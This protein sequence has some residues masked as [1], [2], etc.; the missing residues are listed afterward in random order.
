MRQRAILVAAVLGL[1]M[2]N[3]LALPTA[4]ASAGTPVTP[5]YWP[6]FRF[7][8][9]HPGSISEPLITPA[10][11]STLA[12]AWVSKPG[13]STSS[14]AVV[15][16]VVYSANQADLYAF[17]AADG[18]QLWS[19][20]SAANIES[21]PAVAGG[22]VYVGSLDHDLYAFDAASGQLLWKAATADYI[23]SSAVVA[24]GVV[25]IGSNDHKLYAFD[26]AGT[27]NCSG[28]PKVCLPLW[29]AT[30]AGPVVSTP[31]VAGGTVYVGSD[32][33]KLYAFD[34]AG[35]TGCTGSP[36]TCAPLWTAMTG[37]LVESSP[38]VAGGAVYVGSFDNRLYA[39]DAAG[40]TGCTGSPVTCSPLWTGA[41]GAAI[42]SSPAIDGGRVFVSSWDKHLYAFDAAGATNCSGTPKACLPLWTA[43][44]LDDI[45]ISSP[46]AVAGLVFLGDGTGG[47]RLLAFDGAGVINC[48]G[49]PTVCSPVWSAATPAGVRSSPAVAGAMVYAGSDDGSLNAFAVPVPAAP[50]AGRYHPLPPSRVLDSRDGTGGVS[51]PV[52][53][54]ATVSVTVTGRGGVPAT[55]VSAVVLNVTATGPSAVS[56]LTIFASGSPRPLTSSL[57][58]GPGQT[59][60]N[61]AVS[62]VG[63][64][65]AINVFNAYGHTALVADVVGWYGADGT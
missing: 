65:G 49:A 10:N 43:A 45:A 28:S 61:Q 23:E 12:P 8:P 64:D 32:D 3:L 30:T 59:V 39:F 6:Q 47:N 33:H 21:S 20:A 42:F 26:A 22:V 11:V 34:A 63:P 60:G 50:A 24:S 46:T 2:A 4:N 41:T 53:P 14:P 54:G 36:R 52:G 17:D 15:G 55:G 7:G 9:G 48:S 38:A 40:R 19:A 31:A 37:G 18:H 27:A 57:N 25:Y 51:A 58:F 1:A 56:Y 16:G 35:Q 44:L 62:V 5:A 13:G 29:T